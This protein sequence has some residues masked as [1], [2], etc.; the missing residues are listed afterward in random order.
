MTDEQRRALLRDPRIGD[1]LRE[2]LE[3]ELGAVGPGEH[4]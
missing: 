4:G 2:R 1:A 3:R